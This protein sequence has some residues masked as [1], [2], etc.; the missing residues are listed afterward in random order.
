MSL[1]SYTVFM[2]TSK[3]NS[4]KSSDKSTLFVFIA[5]VVVLGGAK[6]VRHYSVQQE[7]AAV[8]KIKPFDFGNHAFS[9]D[10]KTL[11]FASDSFADGEHMATMSNRT[12]SE[13]GS[14]AAALLIDNPSGSGL[15]S[16][17][18]GA[19]HKDGQE[20]YTTPL[21]LGDRIMF[22]SMSVSDAGEITVEYLDRPTNAPMTA[23]P[24][25]KVVKRFMLSE[26]N[27][28]VEVKP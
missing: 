17:I 11:A 28:L 23:T 6:I 8:A 13:S 9:I 7:V 19:S 21:F 24:T 5:L 25:K 22:T 10:D 26:N 1:S 3:K 15:F 4:K 27:V 18:V 12:I 14:F 16:Y 2:P 20:M